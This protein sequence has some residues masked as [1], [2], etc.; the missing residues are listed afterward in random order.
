MFHHHNGHELLTL[1]EALKNIV[2]RLREFNLSVEEAEKLLDN[3]ELTKGLTELWKLPHDVNKYINDKKPWEA[4]DKDNII[5]TILD[6][7][8][9][10]SILLSP[11]LPE[12]CEKINKQLGIKAGTL[13]D[14]KP[15]LLKEGTKT[16]KGE[17][18]FQKHE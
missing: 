9:I 14:A 18:L 16:N 1:D 7:I 12:T 15:N 17:I 13:K 8:R 2:N 5:Y 6:S 3:L 4:E 11:I 10:I